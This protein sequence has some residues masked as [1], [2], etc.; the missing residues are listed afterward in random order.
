MTEDRI[1]TAIAANIE[2]LGDLLREAA[3][4]TAEAGAYMKTGQRNAAIGTIVDLGA[5]LVAAS[6]LHGA[7]L[8]LHRRIPTT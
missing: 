3:E 6:A 8:A 1:D 5:M 2:A 7:A 4:R